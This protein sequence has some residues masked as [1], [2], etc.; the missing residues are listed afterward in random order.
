MLDIRRIRLEPETVRN[1][2]MKRDPELAPILEHVLLL[3]KERREALM[4]VN[5]LKAERNTASKKVGELKRK[6]EDAEEL[7]TAMRVTGDRISKIDDKIR[8]IDQ[9]LQDLLLA[10]PNTPLDE[11]PE[12]HE[13]ENR[14]EKIW[15]DAPTF[16]FEP[17]PHWDLGTDLDILDLTR[18]SKIS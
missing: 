13:D 3:D 11:V 9:E 16:D 1:A 2:L 5:G 6:G 4:V 8:T 17:L 15:G 10:I 14:T 7:V 18:G 12:G